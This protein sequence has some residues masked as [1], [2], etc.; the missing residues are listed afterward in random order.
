MNITDSS[1]SSSWVFWAEGD[2]ELVFPTAALGFK[3][4]VFRLNLYFFMLLNWC[5]AVAEAKVCSL[6]LKLVNF[7]SA[8]VGMFIWRS[9]GS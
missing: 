4:C 7:N 6:K 8:S 9:V 2:W 1:V 5:C 3:V